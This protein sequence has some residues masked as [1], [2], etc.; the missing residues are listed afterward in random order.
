MEEKLF[1]YESPVKNC[2]YILG[3]DPAK[4]TGENWSVIQV[5]K[6]ESTNPIKMKQVAVFSDNFTDVYTFSDIINRLSYYYNNAYIM[7]ESNGEG[8]AVVNRLWW[9]LE[10]ENLINTGVKEKDLGIRATKSRKQKAI[11]LMKKLIEDYSL[12]L[13]DKETIEQ[14][15]S[16]VEEKEKFFGK[17]KPDDRVSALYWACYI[18]EMD[19]LDETYKFKA[20]K[21]DDSWGILSDVN[22]DTDDWSWLR[23]SNFID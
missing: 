19:I 22:T 7:V 23:S 18:L 14:L 16:F 8:S 5:L 17:D 21:E 6:V 3:V 15:T 1:V 2:I 20:N 11:L 4:G 10:N 12:E 9:E 13:V